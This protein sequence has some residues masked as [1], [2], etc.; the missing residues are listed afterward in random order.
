MFFE[1]ESDVGVLTA[2]ERTGL[3][4]R[5][6][7]VQVNHDFGAD[8]TAKMLAILK[9]TNSVLYNFSF[10]CLFMCCFEVGSHCVALASLELASSP[11]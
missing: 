3:F 7:W 4:V 2:L 10:T 1:G 8:E 6:S 11:G 5:R 9:I